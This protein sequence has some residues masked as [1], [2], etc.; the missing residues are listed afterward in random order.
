MNPKPVH[1][2]GRSKEDLR[3]LPP[4]VAREFGFALW[5]AQMGEKHL[6]AKPLKGFKGA[7]V[8]EI[9]E[10]HAGDTF[11]AVYTIRFAKAIYV[12]HVFQTKS[13]S[14]IKTPRHELDLIEARLKWA[15]A[16]YE[17]WLKEN[18]DETHSK[19]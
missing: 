3:K 17:Q 18:D 9:I 15:K 5:F 13:K 14:G 4:E 11:R 19:N 1:W 2:I 8:L 6:S 16:D 7:G 12:L 10:D